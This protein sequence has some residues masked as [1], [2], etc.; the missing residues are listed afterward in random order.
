MWQLE[1]AWT[2]QVLEPPTAPTFKFGAATAATHNGGIPLGSAVAVAAAAP[3]LQAAPV[4]A[5]P[6]G[7]RSKLAATASGFGSR[8]A[9]PS[10][11]G[12][13]DKAQQDRSAVNGS[14]PPARHSI[15]SL[16]TSGQG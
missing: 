5:Q 4:R 14:S 11:S 12:S 8:T 13:T 2:L 3:L 1:S 7:R 9:A 16:R 6:V 15:R 10:R